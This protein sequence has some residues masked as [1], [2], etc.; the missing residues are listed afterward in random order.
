MGNDATGPRPDGA[1][2]TAAS[3]A[4]RSVVRHLTAALKSRN[5]AR[6]RPVDLQSVQPRHMGSAKSKRGVFVQAHVT[7]VCDAIKEM[8]QSCLIRLHVISLVAR[9]P[10]AD[11]SHREGSPVQPLRNWRRTG[12]CSEAAAAGLSGC[13][14]PGPGRSH[15]LKPGRPGPVQCRQ[16]NPNEE[17]EG[18]RDEG[19]GEEQAKPELEHGRFEQE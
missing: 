9:P 6:H 13:S 1:T 17:K 18:E 12:D 2:A 19:S 10:T 16:R 8:M 5:A 14:T 4:G 11:L 15:R 3:R 7:A